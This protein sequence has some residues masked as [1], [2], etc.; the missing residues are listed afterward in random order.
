MSRL[1]IELKLRALRA[2]LGARFRHGAPVMDHLRDAVAALEQQ[3]ADSDLDYLRQRLQFVLND[4]HLSLL[5][6]A[7]PWLILQRDLYAQSAQKV[8]PALLG[9][10]IVTSDGRAAR[11]TEVVAS[12]KA[13]ERTALS[14][15]RPGRRDLAGT[16]FLPDETG[17]Q[18]VVIVCGDVDDLSSVAI[19]SIE[20]LEGLALMAGACGLTVAEA[21]VFHGH[22]VACALGLSHRHHGM[23]LT[24]RQSDIRI[25]SIL[26][27]SPLVIGEA[28]R[29][30]T[31]GREWRWGIPHMLPHD[32]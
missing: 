31:A 21:L 26:Q 6:R 14:D 7:N 12:D 8:G 11:I 32:A 15:L 30:R 24:R 2:Q 4:W 13:P 3:T 28:R 29:R 9:H 17:A 27:A 5:I 19:T 20:P 25:A 22:A 18:P 23:D 1:R 16:L 10:V